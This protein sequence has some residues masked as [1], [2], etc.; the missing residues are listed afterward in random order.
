MSGTER[1]VGR[2][3]WTGRARYAT[4]ATLLAGLLLT[5]RAYAER[6]GDGP[7]IS[8]SA[9]KKGGIVV[10]WPRV[11]GAGQATA[12]AVQ[13]ALALIAQ[14]VSPVVDVRPA[15]ERVCPRDGGCRGVALGA[16]VVEREQGCAVVAT[17]SGPGMA[18][19]RLLEWAGVLT[20]TAPSVPF[21][22]A[23]ETAVTIADFVPCDTL[24]AALEAGVGKLSEVLKG[25]VGSGQAR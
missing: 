16:V 6:P 4:A 1:Q 3:V 22:E 25:T 24:P 15:P 11:D 18:P 23:P 8:R 7:E 2:G 21:R 19:A 13:S 20:L 9:G 12:Q 17:V 14:G 10:L 5:G